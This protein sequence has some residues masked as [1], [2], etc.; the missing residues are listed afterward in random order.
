M[1]E[2]RSIGTVLSAT[3]ERFGCAAL[4]PEGTGSD[5]GAGEGRPES[6]APAALAD[7]V[8][9]KGGYHL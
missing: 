1:D 7:V 6:N 3:A 8:R 9:G 5:P 2:G 4:G